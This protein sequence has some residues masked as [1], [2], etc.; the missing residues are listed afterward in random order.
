MNQPDA[1]NFVQAQIIAHGIVQGVNF[2]AYA[3]HKARLLGL[4]GWV[5]N[6]P[7][8]TVEAVAEG[9]EA[10]LTDFTDLLRIGPPASRVTDL[11]ISWGEATGE[12]SDFQIRP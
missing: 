9:A 11:E 4:T 12:F 1:A 7:D 2:R 3:Q 5:R 10:A 6:L 8:G